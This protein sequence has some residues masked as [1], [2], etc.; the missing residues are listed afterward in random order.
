[1]EIRRRS[2]RRKQKLRDLLS[3]QALK[4]KLLLFKTAKQKAK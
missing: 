4:I 1:M 2:Q 3:V